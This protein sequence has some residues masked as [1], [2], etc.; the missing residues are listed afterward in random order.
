MHNMKLSFGED[1]L[2][3][4]FLIFFFSVFHA[5]VQPSVY[6]NAV[7]QDSSIRWALSKKNGP[8]TSAILE[9]TDSRKGKSIDTPICAL[10][11]QCSSSSACLSKPTV[12]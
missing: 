6:Q 11:F 2:P 5:Q 3:S 4:V 7:K 1:G 12:H 8:D 9:P 10:S